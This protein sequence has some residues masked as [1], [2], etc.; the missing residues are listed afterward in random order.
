MS[1]LFSEMTMATAT[2]DLVQK[3]MCYL[4]LSNYASLQPDLALLV[5]NTVPDRPPSFPA[6]HPQSKIQGPNM[7]AP[8][9][10]LVPWLAT[11]MAHSPLNPEL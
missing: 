9:K 11:S 8:L 2:H 10:I 3:K 4:Y 6:M 1:G 5:I 7:A